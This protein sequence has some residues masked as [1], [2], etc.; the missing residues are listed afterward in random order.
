MSAA[1]PLPDV[2]FRTQP[3]AERR[4]RVM[5]RMCGR[6][7]LDRQARMWGL[8]DGCRQ[9]LAVRA[10]PRPTGWEVTQETLPGM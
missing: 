1:E 3:P 4:V 6:P 10:A 2:E 8:G 9:K 7:L 5:C